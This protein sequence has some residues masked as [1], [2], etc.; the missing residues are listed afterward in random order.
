MTS[1]MMF[2][3]MPTSD[4]T[5]AAVDVLMVAAQA[6]SQ[7]DESVCGTVIEPG[8]RRWEPPRADEL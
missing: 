2:T 4:T 3:A 7:A 6:M 5:A 1:S 8:F